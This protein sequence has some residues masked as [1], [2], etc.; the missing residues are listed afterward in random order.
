MKR[1]VWLFGD[2]STQY[3]GV[4]PARALPGES[5]AEQIARIV[6]TRAPR[7]SPVRPDLTVRT[8][9]EQQAY[10]TALG[11]GAKARF[12]GVISAE[13]YAAAQAVRVY[14]AAWTWT[15]PAPVIDI[16]MAKARDIHRHG[17]RR[18]R[19]P[20]M[21]ALDVAYMRAAELGNTTEKQRIAALK[22]ALRDV[23]ADPRIEAAATPEELRTVVPT[24]LM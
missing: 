1:I 19:K 2:G 16:D 18:L 10:E 13:T 23:T 17:L 3:T 5:E 4:D 7:I 9:A 22:Q 8:E 14:R 11:A 12:V 20:K 15:T 24:A 6:R 21:E